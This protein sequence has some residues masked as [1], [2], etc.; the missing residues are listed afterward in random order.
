MLIEL[1]ATDASSIAW[2]MGNLDGYVGVRSAASHLLWSIVDSKSHLE[3][4]HLLLPTGRLQCRGSSTIALPLSKDM[5]TVQ[6]WAREHRGQV[7]TSLADMHK[8]MFHLWAYNNT[9]LSVMDSRFIEAAYR[10]WGFGS[11]LG[12]S[13]FRVG[14]GKQ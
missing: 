4:V 10:V 2:S 11:E 3:K 14:L 9:K 13:E 5:N 6:K 1:K 8:K 12:S 7:F